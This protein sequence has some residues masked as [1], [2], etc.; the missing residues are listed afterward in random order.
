[1]FCAVILVI[2]LLY[3][4]H[5]VE[6]MDVRTYA[7]MIRAISERGLPYWDNGPID[8]FPELVVQWAVPKDGHVWGIYGPLYPY[9][10]APIFRLGGL[11]RVSGFTFSM[12]APLA[13]VTYLLARRFVRNEWYAT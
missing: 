13:L 4:G 12:L 7:Q 10:A 5:S 8:R 3:R 9:L 6:S 11:E 2:A 1:A